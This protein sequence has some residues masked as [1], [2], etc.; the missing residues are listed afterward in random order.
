MELH[1]RFS[2]MPVCRVQGKF[3]V[4]FYY[5][6]SDA[7]KRTTAASHLCRLLTF[8]VL[9]GVQDAYD[10][11]SC[12]TSPFTCEKKTNSYKATDFTRAV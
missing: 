2:S 6:F 11:N 7:F 4:A 1:L 10:E 8:L 5:I 9:Y 12:L 3:T